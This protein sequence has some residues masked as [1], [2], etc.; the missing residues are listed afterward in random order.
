M[1]LVKRFANEVVGPKVREMDEKEN[2]DSEVIKGL[3]EQ[4]VWR[5]LHT[6]LAEPLFSC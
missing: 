5:P 6:S 2:M 1:H 3:F 4:G